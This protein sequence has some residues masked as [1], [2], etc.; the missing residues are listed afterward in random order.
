MTYVQ[1]IDKEI[2]DRSMKLANNDPEK[3][4][5]LANK[6]KATFRGDKGMEYQIDKNA[7]DFYR[8][9]HLEGYSI[10][11]G[12]NRTEEWNAGPWG[13]FGKVLPIGG[14]TQTETTVPGDT[15]ANIQTSAQ[16]QTA[17]QEVPN[18]DNVNNAA[19]AM[20]F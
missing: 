13:L 10:Q 3:A 4:M 20:G 5:T 7:V 15:R 16:D 6:E 12:P 19:K 1:Q 14:L 11:T 18:S 17:G 8:T 2:W 9:H